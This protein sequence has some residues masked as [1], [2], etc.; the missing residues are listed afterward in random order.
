[1]T[2]HER[3]A[4]RKGFHGTV[5]IERLVRELTAPLACV[6]VE[7]A[8]AP[9]D[10]DPGIRLRRTGC[11]GDPVIRLLP[12]CEI[13][14]HRLQHPG[15]LVKRHA[16]KLRTA[17]FACVV[18]HAFE[19]DSRRAG[20]RHKLAGDGVNE[21]SPVA[22]PFHPFAL[23][24]VLQFHR[25]LTEIDVDFAQSSH[26]DQG[27]L[28]ESYRVRL[29][30]VIV[31]VHWTSPSARPREVQCAHDPTPLSPV[32]HRIVRVSFVV[33]TVGMFLGIACS[34]VAQSQNSSKRASAIR[35][36]GPAPRVDGRLDEG[37]WQSAPAI[38]DFEQKRPLE[39]VPPT[40]RTQVSI[41]YDN[42]AL[43]VGA[44]MYRNDP[45]RI[46]R[47][48][49]R[50]DSYAN[51]E[52]LSITLDT[53]LDRRTAF[54][55]VI[56]AAGVK[57][58]YHLSSDDEMHGRERQY[59]PVWEG[60]A[61]VDSLGWS[62]EMRIPFS[63]LRFSSAPRQ[64]WG[65]QLNRWIPDKNEDIMWVAVPQRETGFIS[66]FGT[67][68]GLEGIRATRPVELL[69]YIAGDATRT[70]NV[71][72]RN[73]FRNPSTV[74]LGMDAKFGIGP[75]L[76]L[77]AT[78][79]P[80]FG[81]VEADPATVNLTAFETIFEERR[82][83]FIEGSQLIRA[84]GPNYFYSRRIGAPPHLE[85]DGDYVD[86][87]RASTILGAAK[88]TGRTASGMSIGALLAVTDAERARVVP[89]G[90]GSTQRVFVEP[91]SAY[92]V[93]RLQQEMGRQASTLG[94]TLAGMRRELADKPGLAARLSR[95]ALA[96]G[97]DWRLR[98]Q[99]GKY[100][101]TGWAGFS[102]LAGDA[103]A[104]AEK[105][106][107]SAHYFARPDADHLTYDPS[108]RSMTGYT[109]S[110]RAD[111]DAGDRILWGAQV[112]TESQGY[113]V[114]D[115]GRL[116]SADDIDYNADIQFRETRPGRFLRSW[117]LGIV[118][119]GSYNYGLDHE[120]NQWSQ[121][122]SLTTR[123]L[124]N[125]NLQS[126]VDLRH[127]DDGLT[128]GGPLMGTGLGW[129]QDVRLSNSFGARTGWRVN[130]AWRRDELGGHRNNIGGGVTLRPSP[131]WQLSVD[132]LYQSGTDARQ[133]VM[134]LS[135]PSAT[136]TFGG[137]YVFAFVD[138]TTISV[139]TRLNYAV[140]PTLTLEGYGEPFAA[141]GR[142]YDFG[143]L[144]APRG[145]ELRTYGTD[146]TNITR[147]ADGAYDVAAG[148]TTFS[149]ANSDFNVL[150]FRSNLVLRWEW[151]PGSTLYL[152]WQQNRE[153]LDS[154]GNRVRVGDLWSTTRADGDNYLA[155]KVSY[156]FPISGRG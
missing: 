73:P 112:I 7:R 21:F 85:I 96:G 22:A 123:N 127:L 78:I 145:R 110:I 81:Q 82:P 98:F 41:A 33:T 37:I 50:R 35:L 152:V 132:P 77:D 117:Q 5:Y 128:R 29:V 106:L 65:M 119:R 102:Y 94:F 146:G 40:E 36:S 126:L 59:D 88:L 80:D 57:G 154:I 31:H 64:E 72:V 104:I 151:N 136:A 47:A 19:V 143:E 26:G 53:Q 62:A 92:S 90:G 24:I 1:M 16:S 67:L 27:R 3:T 130:Y 30:V 150:S 156:W 58:D 111:K 149:I 108:R 109:T 144:R 125:F 28:R 6:D 44:R 32:I 114:N 139:R 83:F 118:T 25:N 115:M 105:Q 42:D 60:A 10:I 17:G 2:P 75:N 148:A 69:P 43:Y 91:R 121:N 93:V 124:W 137:R 122:T 153:S 61:I 120:L 20:L 103:A 138:R 97:L 18:R 99:Q 14:R 79:N 129:G 155:V 140:S 135:D 52:F 142:F 15:A 12:F 133:Y 51:A 86:Q 8:D 70:A 113:N 4:L 84:D 74:R 9:V 56:S 11:R 76:T 13:L 68:V 55:F 134:Q 71:D 39:G 46:P 141:S 63:Q 116:Q 101:L 54:G 131:S 100:A 34:N 147:S 107:S 95:E 45:S 49:S 23:H 89:L 66:R 38:E 87:P 48:I